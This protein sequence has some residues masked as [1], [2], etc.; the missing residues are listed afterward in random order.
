MR[1]DIWDDLA[2]WG[3]G[4]GGIKLV[5][6]QFCYLWTDELLPGEQVVRLM[7]D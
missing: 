7:L 5:L 2:I 4:G 1:K 3:K 6:V